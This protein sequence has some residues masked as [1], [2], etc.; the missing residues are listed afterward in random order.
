MFW[1]RNRIHLFGLVDCGH[2]FNRYFRSNDS[3]TVVFLKLKVIAQNLII[4]RITCNMNFDE[5]SFIY[6]PLL[7]GH[8]ASPLARFKIFKKSLYR[9]QLWSVQLEWKCLFKTFLN[10]KYLFN[11]SSSYQRQRVSL[12]FFFKFID[13]TE[14]NFLSYCNLNWISKF[15][16]QSFNL[17]IYIAMQYLPQADMKYCDGSSKSA[18]NRLE[19]LWSTRCGC[20]VN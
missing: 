13:A 11:N 5:T 6:L 14:L 16:L 7:N 15:Y 19:D 18:P 8:G 10:K 1:F 2:Y 3:F 4:L 9:F 12:D 17:N 20:E